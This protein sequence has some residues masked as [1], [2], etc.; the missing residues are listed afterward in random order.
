MGCASAAQ[1]TWGHTVNATRAPST[2]A[3]A[4]AQQSRAP[5]AG[6]VTVTAGSAS[7]TRPCTERCMGHA[8]NVMTSRV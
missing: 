2:P 4:R 3:P 1:G 8:V 7:A 6:E 5:A